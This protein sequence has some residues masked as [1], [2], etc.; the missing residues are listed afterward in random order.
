[1]GRRGRWT[2]RLS[3]GRLAE[4]REDERDYKDMAM[5]EQEARNSARYN[6]MEGYNT[7]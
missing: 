5:Q 2:L 4:G 6:P 7:V 3:W 1:M